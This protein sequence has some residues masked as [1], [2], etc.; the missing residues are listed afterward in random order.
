M[1]A[2]AGAHHTWPGG[3]SA[4][5]MSA[6]YCTFLKNMDNIRSKNQALMRTRHAISRAAVSYQANLPP[7]QCLLQTAIALAM[8]PA[9]SSAFHVCCFC[10]VRARL[11]SCGTRCCSLTRPLAA[12]ERSSYRSLPACP[13]SA[14]ASRAPLQQ[15]QL[16][17]SRLAGFSLLHWR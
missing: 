8:I 7:C 14:A 12:T 5:T 10:T 16:Q 15:L 13:Q 17:H 4:A 9:Y 3:E 11:T 2:A 6:L 1:A